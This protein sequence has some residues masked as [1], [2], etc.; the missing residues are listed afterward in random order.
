MTL[1]TAGWIFLITAWGAIG[2]LTAWTMYQV[3]YASERRKKQASPPTH[4]GDGS[5]GSGTGGKAAGSD[6]SRD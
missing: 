3:L 6:G 2:G 1:S 5:Q 4:P